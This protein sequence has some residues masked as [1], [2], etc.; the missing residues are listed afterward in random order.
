MV[1]WS[2][3]AAFLLIEYGA[4][5]DDIIRGNLMAAQE[6]QDIFPIEELHHVIRG[7]VAEALPAAGV[8]VVHHPGNVFLRE[9]VN[10]FSFWDEAADEFVVALSRTFLMRGRRVTVE[11][12]RPL[13]S[14]C[15]QLDC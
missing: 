13:V 7:L 10:A 2:A 15:V 9:A 8:D 11:H 4:V 14:L 1:S 5:H 3:I 6:L 12:V